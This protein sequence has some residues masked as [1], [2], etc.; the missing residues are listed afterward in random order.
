MSGCEWTTEINR[1]PQFRRRVLD[2]NPLVQPFVDVTDGPGDSHDELVCQAVESEERSLEVEGDKSRPAVP[3]DLVAGSERPRQ[4]ATKT[5]SKKLLRK[6][7][8]EESRDDEKQYV[9]KLWQFKEVK[10]E[11]V[12]A[13]LKES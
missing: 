4:P 13:G 6:P 1:S 12:L 10:E 7:V 8:M 11:E 9:Q 5:E 3:V 2:P